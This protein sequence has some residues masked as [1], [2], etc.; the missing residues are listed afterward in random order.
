MVRLTY[1]KAETVEATHVNGKKQ[2]LAVS[3]K[4]T[5]LEAARRN[6]FLVGG[7]V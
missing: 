4:H 6:I 7:F 3:G 1:G 5:L 2:H